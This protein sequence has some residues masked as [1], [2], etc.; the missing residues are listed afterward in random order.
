MDYKWLIGLFVFLWLSIWQAMITVNELYGLVAT[1]AVI[2]VTGFIFSKIY[3]IKFKPGLGE[4]ALAG[5]IWM[6]AF[7][8][9]DIVVLAATGSVFGVDALFTNNY[10]ISVGLIMPAAVAAYY[11]RLPKDVKII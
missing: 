11:L 1:L 9:L 2:F 3:L 4:L 10:L 7:V 6:S 8:I 5:L